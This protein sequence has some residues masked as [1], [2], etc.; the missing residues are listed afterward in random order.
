ML[1][2][3][4]RRQ[5]RLALIANYRNREEEKREIQEEMAKIWTP[6]RERLLGTVD[7]ALKDNPPP[8]YEMDG[9]YICTVDKLKWLDSI[10]QE[11]E[12]EAKCEAERLDEEKKEQ[13]ELD[14]FIDVWIKDDDENPAPID[15]RLLK[16]VAQNLSYTPPHSYLINKEAFLANID[17]MVETV[18]LSKYVVKV[19][20]KDTS[21]NYRFEDW[22]GIVATRICDEYRDDGYDKGVVITYIVNHFATW[23]GG[24]KISRWHAIEEKYRGYLKKDPSP[25]AYT[26]NLLEAKEREFVAANP[27]KCYRNVQT[28]EEATLEE[29]AEVFESMD[30]EQWKDRNGF[31]YEGFK[32]NFHEYGLIEYDYVY[33]LWIRSSAEFEWELYSSDYYKE[34]ELWCLAV[35]EAWKGKM[36]AYTENKGQITNVPASW[37]DFKDSF[38][39][40]KTKELEALNAYLTMA[41]SIL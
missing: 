22:V 39:E 26:N 41:Q 16:I 1:C 13:K 9:G 25:Y 14:D 37:I 33:Q 11:A 3:W 10:A 24:A 8:Q 20:E 17:V 21:L 19:G 18:S 7:Q 28:D 12:Y 2:T 4:C 32:A 5:I 36:V 34:H 35:Q 40:E 27:K 38:L 23:G 15:H 6:E 30:A 29:W 31:R